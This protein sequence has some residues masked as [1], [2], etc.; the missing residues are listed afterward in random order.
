MQYSKSKMIISSVIRIIE[1]T[2]GGIVAF[3]FGITAISCTGDGITPASDLIIMYSF[4]VIGLLL[5]LAGIRRGFLL[6]DVKKYALV[7][8]TIPSGALISVASAL[9]ISQEEAGKRIRKI[10]NKGYF[11]DAYINEKENRIVVKGNSFFQ[12]T[13]ERNTH[14]E[15]EYIVIECSKCGAVNKLEKGTMGKCEFCRCD[16]RA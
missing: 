8:S 16:I 15:P 3:L 6:R 14:S 11:P 2:A 13:S 9:G 1:L 5:I 4:T 7:L 10:I 12:H